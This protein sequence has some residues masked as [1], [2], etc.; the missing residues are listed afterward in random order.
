MSK[1]K[2]HSSLPT[3]RQIAKVGM[4]ASL[5]VLLW[6]AMRGGRRL[7]KYHTA[8]GIA[9]MGFSLWHLSL[10]NGNPRSSRSGE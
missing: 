10:Y 9:L 4:T 7:M 6:T 1:E 8:A 2:N 5:G 3:Q